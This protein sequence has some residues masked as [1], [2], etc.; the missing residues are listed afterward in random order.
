MPYTGTETLRFLH[1]STDTQTFVGQGMERFYVDYREQEDGSCLE[2]HESVRIRFVNPQT[3]DEIKM[4][5]VFDPVFGSTFTF[6]KFYFKNIFSGYYIENFLLT[7]EVN[8][9]IY[10]TLGAFSTT[11]DTSTYILFRFPSSDNQY[12]G[13]VKIKYPSDT[14]TLIR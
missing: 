2:E 8:E 14:L 4:E 1:N 3:Q 11:Q 13:V 6:Y 7:M 10:N 9:H 12:S 5:Y